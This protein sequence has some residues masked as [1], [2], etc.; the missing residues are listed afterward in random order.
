MSNEYVTDPELLKQLNGSDGEYVTDPSIL[1]KLN[2]ET[3][4]AGPVAPQFYPT[5]Q[6]ASVPSGIREGI[7]T[8]KIIAQPTTTA[9]GNVAKTYMSN[10]AAALTDL[11]MGH[12]GLPPPVAGTQIAPGVKESY[13]QV[14]DW[15]SKSGNFKPTTLTGGASP[16]FDAAMST[17][18]PNST[19]LPFQEGAAAAPKPVIGG[20]AASE[21]SNFIQSISQK[22]A[23]MAAKV[24]PILN[25]VGRIA[26]PAGL[27]YNAYEG[28]KYAQDAKLG[29]RLASGEGR[30]AQSV[31]RNANP[32]YGRPVSP[33]EAR[34][35]LESGNPRDIA[36]F[37]GEQR[38]RQL[39][40]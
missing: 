19:P 40:Q 17:P 28:A 22:F 7:N 29:E 5:G 11:T 15:L 1:E 9:L 30:L 23:P 4:Q 32:V 18:H 3:P 8:A 35:I 34:I 2:A 25:T 26:G 20:P 27:A 14:Q 21:G 31:M 38:L 33:E 13:Q 10:P 36:A 16:A 12:F 37:G 39:A 24:A 6:G